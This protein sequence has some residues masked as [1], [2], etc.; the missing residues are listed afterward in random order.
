M[1]GIDYLL[2]ALDKYTLSP[3]YSKDFFGAKVYKISS[4]GASRLTYMKITLVAGK[5]HLKHTEGGDFCEATYRAVRHGLMKS[6]C[7]LLE[8]YYKFRLEIPSACIGRAMS[9]LQLRFAEFEIEYS[10]TERTAN[11]AYLVFYLQDTP[12]SMCKQTRFA[13]VPHST[14][15]SHLVNLQSQRS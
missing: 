11:P 1:D 3:I 10:D 12:Y 14:S 4:A 7:T 9:D 6:G 2:S 13:N 5:A 8:P 15:N